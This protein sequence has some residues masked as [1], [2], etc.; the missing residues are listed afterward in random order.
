MR[1]VLGAELGSDFL[2]PEDLQRDIATFS[3]RMAQQWPSRFTYTEVAEIRDEDTIDDLVIA[4]CEHLRIRARMDNMALAQISVS[5][6]SGDAH[7]FVRNRRALKVKG[8]AVPVMNRPSSIRE[9]DPTLISLDAMSPNVRAPYPLD[10]L[11]ERID[12]LTS[13]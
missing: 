7:L 3:D 11:L 5:I 1:G 2:V 10:D 4:L 12:D 13:E 9:L 6:C 8:L